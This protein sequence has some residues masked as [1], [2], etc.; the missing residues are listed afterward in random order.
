M[1]RTVESRKTAECRCWLTPEMYQ[2]VRRIAFDL[3]ISIPEYIRRLIESDL[4]LRAISPRAANAHPPTG[5][6]REDPG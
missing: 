6:L 2:R 5:P 1:A 4:V 3:E